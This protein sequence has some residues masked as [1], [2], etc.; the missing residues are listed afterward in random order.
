MTAG[1]DNDPIIRFRREALE[2][3]H[4]REAEQRH[5]ADDPGRHV[6]VTADFPGYE[7]CSSGC[8]VLYSRH[9]S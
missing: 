1:P 2:D 8:N 7:M 4:L 5:E 3:T 9:T 6:V